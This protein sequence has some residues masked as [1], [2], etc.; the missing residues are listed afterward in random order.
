VAGLFQPLESLGVFVDRADVCLKDEW[1]RGGGP[2][3]LGGP[4]EVGR[5]PGGPARLVDS[6]PE[7]E[8]VET[9]LGGLQSLDGL[10]TCAAQV[11]D[12]LVFHR[13]DIHGGEIAGAHQAGQWHGVP[14]VGVDAV[15]SLLGKQGR[16]DD[17]TVVAFF[18]S[19]AIPPVATGA[20][21]VD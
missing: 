3:D 21:S 19:I 15:A 1:L 10:F 8:G 16:G 14:A 4:P 17:P 9:A 12:G 18:R 5:A 11:A 6:M 13:R 2:D 20:S 7:P